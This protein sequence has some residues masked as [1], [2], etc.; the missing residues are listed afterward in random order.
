MLYFSIYWMER[1]CAFQRNPF[2]TSRTALFSCARWTTCKN[3]SNLVGVYA[4]RVGCMSTT[5]S[6][7]IFSLQVMIFFFILT[8]YVYSSLRHYFKNFFSK[9][10]ICTRYHIGSSI[11]EWWRKILRPLTSPFSIQSYCLVLWCAQDVLQPHITLVQT[12]CELDF[13]VLWSLS[14]E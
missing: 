8:A 7:N 12:Q 1:G 6:R 3:K 10:C 13:V 14:R 11:L 4:F 9:C 2:V 5:D